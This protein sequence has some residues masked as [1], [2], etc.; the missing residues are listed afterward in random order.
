M[1]MPRRWLWI[2]AGLVLFATP[3]IAE[4]PKLI[5]ISPYKAK[6][7]LAT[8]G[9]GHY[10]AWVPFGKK[11]PRE[12]VNMFYGDGKVFHRPYQNRSRTGIG[13][14]A[15]SFREPRFRSKDSAPGF[16]VFDGVATVRCAER[17]T[18][19]K[20]VPAAETR[21]L[22]DTA[23]FRDQ[24]FTR[25]AYGLARDDTGRYYYVDK[26]NRTPTSRDFKL[27]RGQR[28][29]LKPLNMKNVVFDSGG[30]IFSARQGQLRLVLGKE[31]ATW[32]HRGKRIELLNLPLF[33]NRYLI[34]A[35]LGVYRDVPFGTPC[36]DL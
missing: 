28:G 11:E 1:T 29:N 20:P 31:K 36:D 27:Y 15:F 9:D 6:L 19:L 14:Y 33:P 30:A 16:R 35:E 21:K 26:D 2:G 34:Y 7:R 8:D 18:T 23:E 4:P 17:I 13:R 22:I 5:D 24:L 32:I 10:V 12:H 25:Q 3:A